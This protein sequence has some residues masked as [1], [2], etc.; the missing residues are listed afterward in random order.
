ME[1][2]EIILF[3]TAGA[4]NKHEVTNKDQSASKA[5]NYTRIVVLTISKQDV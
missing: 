1:T 3:M 4:H 5:K 2:T